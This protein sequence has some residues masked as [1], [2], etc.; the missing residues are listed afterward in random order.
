[1]F[2]EDNPSDPYLIPTDRA[3]LDRRRKMILAPVL[4]KAV[5]AG[6]FIIPEEFEVGFDHVTNLEWKMTQTIILPEDIREV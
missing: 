6:N 5:K 1:M 4:E 3:L 2:G